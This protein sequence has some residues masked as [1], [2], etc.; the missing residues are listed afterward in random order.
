MEIWKDIEGYEGKYQVSNTGKVKSLNYNNSGQEKELKQK[1]K[2]KNYLVSTL[3]L[4]TFSPKENQDLKVMHIQDVN[5]NSIDNLKY[6]FTSEIKFNMY[7]R[8]SRKIGKPS[9]YK[10]SYK[11]VVYKNK[12][13]LA[14]DYDIDNKLFHKR[15][16]RG[17]SLEETLEI[18]LERKELR[19][20]KQLYK[21]QDKLYSLKQLEDLSGI[22][23]KA[24]RK[25][26]KRGW[27]V[28]EAVEIPLAKN[29]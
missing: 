15:I 2:T 7:K 21:Y 11:G 18:P 10:I 20:K 1:N 17:W 25:R 4:K 29:K 5:D 12:S 14:R 23:E 28:E 3:V 19:L 24:I 16:E 9:E 22:S 6:G 13:Q 26:L 27:S 8:G